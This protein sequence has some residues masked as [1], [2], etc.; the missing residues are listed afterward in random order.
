MKKVRKIAI[1]SLAL[2]MVASLLTGFCV[3]SFTSK[4][5]EMLSASASSTIRKTDAAID[6]HT[7]DYFDS[8]VVYK[9]PDTI[10]DLQELSVIV[11]MKTEALLDVYATLDTKKTASE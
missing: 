5:E 7:Q 10:S 9:L 4:N 11:K 6:L 8:S 1:K 2:G 3:S